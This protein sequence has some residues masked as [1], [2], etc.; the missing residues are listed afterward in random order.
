MIKIV[1]MLIGILAMTASAQAL[2]SSLDAVLTSQDPFPAEPG[3]T[4]DIEVEIQNNG[5]AAAQDVVVELVPTA[6]FSLLPGEQAAKTFLLVGASDSV[7]AT[8][9]LHVDDQAIS[10]DYELEVRIREGTSTAYLS[11]KIPLAV[12]GKA[13]LVLESVTTDPVEIEAGGTAT[14]KMVVRNVGSGTARHLTLTLNATPELIPLL[15]QGVTYLGDLSPGASATADIDISISRTAE[16]KT[17]TMTLLA[18]YQNESGKPESTSFAIGIP[19]SGTVDL[20][21]I[22]VEPNYAQQSLEIEVANKGTTDANSVEARLLVGGQLVDIDY[23][24]T[25]K[26]TKKTTFSFPLVAEG[27]GT[28]EIRYTGPGLE[29]T[30]ITKD[31]VFSFAAPA[32]DGQPAVLI[33]LVIVI[34]GG[35]WYWRRRRKK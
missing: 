4:V 15:A 17:Y 31:L 18:S 22:K 32:Q 10:G 9:R 14:L 23:I 16:Q 24:S 30:A 35:L 28:L 5:N 20:E 21:I 8:Y 3:A 19:V 12:S 2:S 11:E 7:K 1:A 25:I 29:E 13:T 34:L 33:V 26:P 6:P 27:N